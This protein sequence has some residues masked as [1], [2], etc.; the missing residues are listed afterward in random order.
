[1]NSFEYH[2]VWW[3]AAAPQDRSIGVLRWDATDGATLSLTLTGAVRP[4]STCDVMLGL[5]TDRKKLTLFK[6]FS[7]SLP[8]SIP[9]AVDGEGSAPRAAEVFANEVLVGVHCDSADPL[10]SSASVLFQDLG[11]WW[12]LYGLQHDVGNDGQTVGVRYEPQP[13]VPLVDD[14]VWR[15]SLSTR[16]S[17]SIS[18][19][20]TL[21]EDKATME[22]SSA[23]PQPL[24]DFRRRI[25]A[26]SDFLSVLFGGVTNPIECEFALPAPESSRASR[27]TFHGIPLY[28]G[29]PRKASVRARA[30]L[31]FPEIEEALPGMVSAWLS[32]LESIRYVRALYFVGVH[33]EGL[34]EPKFLALMQAAEAFHRLHYHGVYMDPETFERDVLE[35]MVAA[36]PDVVGKDHRNSLKTRL[37]FANHVS[38]RKRLMELALEHREAL[39]ALV[40]SP[41]DWVGPLCD[42]RNELT[43]L[44]P[45]SKLDVPPERIFVFT[46]LIKLLL[47]CC[48]LKV[49]GLPTTEIATVV[50]RSGDYRQ[51]KVR[52]FDG[53]HPTGP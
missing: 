9:F 51:L 42:Y 27:A 47:E 18:F 7:R 52:F 22:L 53:Q 4:P 21:L 1:M 29:D 41:E 31:Q 49:A 2:G 25:H 50:R 14:G 48:F 35:A 12:G 13:S 11:E 40:D 24:S 3:A 6:C 46:T 45:E 33:G 16:L 44:G 20:R 23:S 34:L 32:H 8:F 5:S 30:L 15:M 37:K 43:H 10:V 19:E 17:G 26:F 36:I 38:Q 28:Q 39:R